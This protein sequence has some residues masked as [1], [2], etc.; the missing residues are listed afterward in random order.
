[1]T[2][3]KQVIEWAIK[4]LELERQQLDAK[5]AELKKSLGSRASSGSAASVTSSPAVRRRRLGAEGRRKI[6]EAKKAWWAKQKQA[7]AAR[8]KSK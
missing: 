2:N 6:S 4:G 7:I 5:L 8:K 1:M 3:N